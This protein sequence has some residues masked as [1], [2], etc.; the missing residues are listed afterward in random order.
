MEN[1][2]IIIET[3]SN[4][5]KFLKTDNESITI[6]YNINPDD[7]L[8]AISLSKGLF[9]KILSDFAENPDF[10]KCYGAF[11][12]QNKIQIPTILY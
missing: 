11:I 5:F 3:S 10:E 7:E 2:D 1:S 8:K 4:I 6:F 9:V 12:E